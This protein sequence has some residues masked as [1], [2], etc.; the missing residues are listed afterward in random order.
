MREYELTYLVSDDVLEKDQKVITDRVAGIVADEGGKVSKE[1]AWGRRKL[2]Y[3]IK[4][5]NFATYTT[6]W[7]QLPKE[8]IV[9]LEHELR[10]H[11]QI[12]RHLIVAKVA[13]GNPSRLARAEAEELVITKEDIVGSEDVE[14]IIGEKSFEQIEGQKEESYDLMAKRSIEATEEP[15]ETKGLKNLP[16]DA[17]ALQASKK[18]KGEKEKP[19]VEEIIEEKPRKP[20]ILKEDKE[21]KEVQDDKKAETEPVVEEK[22][23]TS[24][25]PV[26]EPKE[27]P[28]SV[29]P[30]RTTE[31]KED[32][33]ADRIKKLDEK[34]DELLKDDL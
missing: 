3:P 28:S 18:I 21:E 6:I 33:E 31:S 32:D 34:L 16:A 26:E 27:E 30:R 9:D 25:K 1:E 29:R 10:V 13:K 22:I 15:E 11:P 24:E 17:T 8:K 20:K 2:T 19:V 5:Q 14:K 12:V 4:K 23:E 7:F